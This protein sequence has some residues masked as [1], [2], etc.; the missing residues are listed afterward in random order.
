MSFI[1]GLPD[2]VLYRICNNLDFFDLLRFLQ[3]PQIR[4]KSQKFFKFYH[5]ESEPAMS[6]T[7]SL[8]AQSLACL[9]LCDMDAKTAYVVVADMRVKS[10]VKISQGLTNVQQVPNKIV[11]ICDWNKETQ[12]D[13]DEF[14]ISLIETCTSSKLIDFLKLESLAL[15]PQGFQIELDSN[16][17]NFPALNRLEIGHNCTPRGKTESR[18]N[19]PLLQEIIIHGNLDSLLGLFDLG[20]YTKLKTVAFFD[21]EKSIGFENISLPHCVDVKFSSSALAANGYLYKVTL[22]NC[23]TLSLYGVSRLKYVD[24]P[25]LETLSVTGLSVDQSVQVSN[26]RAPMLRNILATEEVRSAFSQ[27]TN[28]DKRLNS[29]PIVFCEGD[30]SDTLR[31]IENIA[32]LQELEISGDEISQLSKMDL[33]ALNL[34]KIDLQ[35][36]QDFLAFGLHPSIK[37]LELRNVTLNFDSAAFETCLFSCPKLER[38]FVELQGDDVKIDGVH[39]DTLS[40]LQIETTDASTFELTNCAFSNLTSF[41]FVSLESADVP[42]VGKIEMVAKRLLSFFSELT[43]DKIDFTKFQCSRIQEIS[44]HAP[45]NDIQLGDIAELY[46]LSLVGPFQY[47]DYRTEPNV[48]MAIDLP[49]EIPEDSLYVIEKFRTVIHEMMGN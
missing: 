4:A 48:L 12:E 2:D 26:F 19:I 42:P 41:E 10:K 47:I 20:S 45:V 28:T 25:I 15:D 6:I 18:F 31:R 5:D 34:L 16:V 11:L 38:L 9:N 36:C 37:E 22:P 30:I 44:L 35:H 32:K 33:P 40:N 43:M 49:D 1:L 46:S 27:L 29:D 7:N 39:L 8:Q 14:C 13:I 23:K 17:L 3:V 24:A 21:D